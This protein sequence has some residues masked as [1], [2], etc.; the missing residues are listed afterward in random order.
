[1]K[2]ILNNSRYTILGGLI[3]AVLL[4]PGLGSLLCSLLG[5]YCIY[6]VYK[7]ILR[8]YKDK[9]S[10]KK[11]TIIFLIGALVFIFLIDLLWHR[12]IYIFLLFCIVK[13]IV[14]CKDY[15]EKMQ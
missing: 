2:I 6:I 11:I 14:I 9:K 12:L 13:L 1:M 10:K 8:Y 15:Y 5:L 4:F 7:I 3:L